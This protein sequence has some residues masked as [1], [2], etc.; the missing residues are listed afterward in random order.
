MTKAEQVTGACAEHGEGGYVLATGG[1]RL[2]SPALAPVSD[3]I[4]AFDDPAIRMTDGGCDP[5]GRFYCGSMAYDFTPG[6]RCAVSAQPG[7]VRSTSAEWRD[8]LQRH[9]LAPWRP[10]GLLRRHYDRPC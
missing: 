5:Q 1:F 2:L 3:E 9:P 6:R 10:A 8:G 7:P 4:V